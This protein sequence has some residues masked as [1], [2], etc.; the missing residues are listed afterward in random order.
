[1]KCGLDKNI[2][3]SMRSNFDNWKTK[4]LSPTTKE[5]NIN[6]YTASPL[7]YLKEILKN[8]KYQKQVS[9]LSFLWSTL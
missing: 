6:L 3:N 4:K 5:E 8:Y 2:I 1:M 9:F 7:N